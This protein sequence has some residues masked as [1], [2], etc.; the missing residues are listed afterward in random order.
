MLQVAL[1]RH[2]K[3]GMQQYYPRGWR[4]VRHDLSSLVALMLVLAVASHA[5][6]LAQT[7][8]GSGAAQLYRV[9]AAERL[10]LGV[11]RTVHVSLYD[12]DWTDRDLSG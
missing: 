1:S 9:R 6:V 10:R 8:T 3:A 5:S 12:Q 7:V 11:L 2:G 4:R